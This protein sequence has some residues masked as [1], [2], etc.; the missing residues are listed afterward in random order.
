MYVKTKIA[1]LMKSRKRWLPNN[2]SSSVL[3]NIQQPDNNI[4][5]DSCDDEKMLKQILLNLN[6]EL[7]IKGKVVLWNAGYRYTKEKEDYWRCS[8]RDCPARAKAKEEAGGYKG[9]LT[10]KEHNHPAIIQKKICEEVRSK[11]KTTNN[12][13]LA[14]IRANVPDEVFVSLGTDDALQKLV[15]RQKNKLY[16]NINLTD[17]TKMTIPESFV[18]IDGSSTLIYDSRNVRGTDDVV[19]IFSHPKLLNILAANK[20]WAIDG[21]F[22]VA[23]KP[24]VQC[25]C[26]GTFVNR[27]IVVCVQ[28]LLPS[29]RACHYEETLKVLRQ[30]ISPNEPKKVIID[31]EKAEILALQKTFPAVQLSAC[32]FHF[33]Q[34]LFR[35]WR[36]LGLNRLFGEGTDEGESSRT[37]FR[38]I[39][40][41]ALIPS[42]HVRRGF[43]L[44]I[45]SSP[46]IISSFLA[47]FGSTYVGLTEMELQFGSEAFQRVVSI[48]SL[49]ESIS[50]ALAD[51][52]FH[53]IMSSTPI[54]FGCPSP[55]PSTPNFSAATIQ[56]WELPIVRRPVYP[57]EFWNI[58]ER[59]LRALAKN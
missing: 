7:Q 18:Q 8:T 3:T 33:G 21:T 38:R 24:F 29:K 43:G 52:T 55:Q 28:A 23:P 45:N 27:R 25:F 15:R 5:N 1:E 59:A 42:E 39:L 12:V 50:S 37:S 36:D 49:Q 6:M 14:E 35:K 19:L 10:K 16:G 44:I 20:H 11:I 56:R 41:L 9:I 17:M 58:N 51:H 54:Q 57:I 40:A 26:V 34:S 48:H 47:Y 53:P 22:A 30:K 32:L 46:A 4:D 31:F 13:V 2:D